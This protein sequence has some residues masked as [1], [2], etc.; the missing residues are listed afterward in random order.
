M[1]GDLSSTERLLKRDR[2]IV[3]AGLAALTLLAWGPAC[4]CA[5]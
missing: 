1:S 3:L 2:A 5:T 4:R